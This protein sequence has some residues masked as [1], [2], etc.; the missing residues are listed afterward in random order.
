MATGPLNSNNSNNKSPEDT[1]S[2]ASADRVEE[3]TEG[4]SDDVT[5]QTEEVDTDVTSNSVN[6]NWDDILQK[7]LKNKRL[8]QSEVIT[9]SITSIESAIVSQVKNY[10]LKV[11]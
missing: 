2:N 7:R 8:T 4:N 9:K 1:E 3:H 6:N 11:C 5:N 10:K